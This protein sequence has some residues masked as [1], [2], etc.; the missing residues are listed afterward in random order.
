M[1]DR[2]NCPPRAT[3]IPVTAPVSITDWQQP[4]DVVEKVSVELCARFSRVAL[5]L[6][7][8]SERLVGRSERSIFLP[9][10]WQQRA[11]TFST[12]SV[13]NGAC[14]KIAD[15]RDGIVQRGDTAN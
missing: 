15:Q 6:T 7:Y 12:A 11:T 2:K 3:G 1:R 14:L 4:V 5:P 10:V 13:A 9:V 8:P